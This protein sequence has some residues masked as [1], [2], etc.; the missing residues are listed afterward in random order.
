M[1][2]VVEVRVIDNGRGIEPGKL[3]NIFT[4]FYSTKGQQGTGLGL[5]VTRKIVLEHQGTL[6]V[7]SKVDQGTTFTITIST[8]AHPGADS[9]DTSMPFGK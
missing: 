5:A 8:T 9:S 6:D 4:P 3:A 7:A 1:N 2:R